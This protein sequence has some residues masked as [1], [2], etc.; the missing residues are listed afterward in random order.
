[1]DAAFA[2]ARADESLGMRRLIPDRETRLQRLVNSHMSPGAL[3][4]AGIDRAPLALD[5]C[6]AKGAFSPLAWANAPGTDRETR[7]QRLVD[8]YMLH[9]ALPQ[10]GIDRAPLALDTRSAKGAF[11]PLAW[12]NAPGTDRETRLQRL[13]DS[14]ILPGAL[15]QAGIDRAP[16]AVET[17]SAEGA[18]SPLACGNAPG[19]IHPQSPDKAPTARFIRADGQRRERVVASAVF[20][21]QI[22]PITRV[23]AL[24]T[25]HAP[26]DGAA[27]RPYQN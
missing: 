25:A 5:T 7:L 26:T 17:C 2:L 20:S 23:D 11:S 21:G 9:G 12:A 1:V 19:S 13:V 16:L 8:S 24:G 6:S 18:S 27:R 10:A 4:Q 14:H 3:P 22:E 15:P